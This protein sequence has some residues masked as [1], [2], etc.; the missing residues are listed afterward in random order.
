MQPSVKD[1][2]E[3]YA[4]ALGYGLADCREV[5]RWG[6]NL[7]EQEGKPA[8]WLID[9]S[10][11]KEDSPADAVTS[12][13]SAPGSIAD[14]VPTKMLLVRARKFWRQGKFGSSQIGPLLVQLVQLGLLPPE[15]VVD[16][17]RIDDGFDL[18]R[19]N[20]WPRERAETAL[21]EFFGKL[22]AF[23]HLEIMEK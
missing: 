17:Y 16:A 6:D 13:H 7:I 19:S 21:D 22:T 2:A 12:L 5:L 3:F 18:A 9:L 8:S 15:F 1:T 4:L 10:L 14:F 20:A 11:V 23:E